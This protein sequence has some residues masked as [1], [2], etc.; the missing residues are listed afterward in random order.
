MAQ[1][2]Q[3]GL[4]GWGLS[5][6]V[7]HVPFLSHRP[8]KFKIKAVLRSKRSDSQ[9]AQAQAQAA[10]AMSLTHFPETIVFDEMSKFLECGLDLAVIASPN[11]LHF[12][13]ARDCLERGLHVVVEKPFTL[14]T[15][16]A[17]ELIHLAQS[18]SLVLAV[19]HNRTFD[20]DFST[21]KSILSSGD[22]LLGRIVQFESSVDR[23]R[24]EPREGSWREMPAGDDGGSGILFDLG[25]HLIQQ[26]LELFSPEQLVSVCADV[27]HQRDFNRS[28]PD[29]PDDAFEVRLVFSSGVRCVLKASMLAN[30]P[31]P[32]FSVRG[33]KSERL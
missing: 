22:H 23:F 30:Q 3:V 8:E 28:H 10:T 12:P 5:A 20:G 24:P 7:F 31:G 17:D 6:K 2:L 27:L 11:H 26:A 16:E 9:Q 15:A 29:A 4:I 33:S 14:T 19:F 25:P 1:I 18:R 21:I 13:M 32:R